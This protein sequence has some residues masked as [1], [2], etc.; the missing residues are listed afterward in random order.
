MRTV[1]VPYW[2]LQAHADEVYRQELGIPRKLAGDVLSVEIS[3]HRLQYG[4]AVN[5]RIF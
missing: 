5:T 4:L 3:F 1:R 2:Q